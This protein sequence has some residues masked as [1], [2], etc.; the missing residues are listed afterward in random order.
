MRNAL[1]RTRR[2][3]GL[4]HKPKKNQERRR[5][6]TQ[7]K[8]QPQKETRSTAGIRGNLYARLSVPVTARR[9]EKETA[10]TLARQAASFSPPRNKKKRKKEGWGSFFLHF[11]GRGFFKGN[12]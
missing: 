5:N 1:K 6:D 8:S 12:R 10:A 11:K 9:G 3:S 4:R 2:K 7:T